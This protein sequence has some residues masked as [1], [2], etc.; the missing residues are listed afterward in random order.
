[1]PPWSFLYHHMEQPDQYFEIAQLLAKLLKGTITAE[2]KQ[3]LSGWIAESDAH[4]AIADKLTDSIYLQEKLQTG[5]NRDPNAA[6]ERLRKEKDMRI[7][8]KRPLRSVLLRAAAIVLPLLCLAG[9]AAY[10]VKQR[11]GNLQTAASEMKIPAPG[12][13][14]ARLVLGNGRTVALNDTTIQSIKE[15]DGTNISN[16]KSVLQYNAGKRAGQLLLNTLITPRGGEYQLV[17]SDGTKVW[18]N[19]ASSLRFPVQFTGTE[20]Q[21]YLSG[22]AYFEVA[23][24]EQRPFKISTGKMNITVLG[25]SFNVR[26]YPEEEEEKT[27]LVSGAVRI[28]AGRQNSRGSGIALSPGWQAVVSGESNRVEKGRA[29]LEEALAWKNGLFVFNREPV[30]SIMRKIARWYDVD[31]VFESDAVRNIHFTARI[32]KHE[33]LEDVMKLLTLT[34]KITYRLSN[35]KIYVN[36]VANEGK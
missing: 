10:L 8:V 14:K 2:E 18:M 15:E 13:K 21:V 16:G 36:L 25:T 29:N 5:V 12:G 26:A 4:R 20:R 31:V 19:A 24:N 34:N 3:R 9:A 22:E 23:P 28:A 6:W 35:N 1:M 27:M 33:Q 32:R 7:P 17:L 30:E 11:N